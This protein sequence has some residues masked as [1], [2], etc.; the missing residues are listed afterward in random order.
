MHTF[1][2]KSCKKI[3][4]VASAGPNLTL[5]SRHQ[6]SAL[7]GGSLRTFK[8]IE[9]PEE[10]INLCHMTKRCEG[11]EYYSE[12]YP[13]I[14]KKK[15]CNL[16]RSAEGFLEEPFVTSGRSFYVCLRTEFHD[17]E[18]VGQN[19]GSLRVNN[20]QQCSEACQATPGCVG[21]TQQNSSCFLKSNIEYL[22]YLPKSKSEQVCYRPPS[23]VNM[24]VN[25]DDVLGKCL[26]VLFLMIHT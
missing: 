13:D 21:F 15:I 14:W 25:T 23:Y 7:I 8:N 12:N 26:L 5:V 20:S 10:C 16:K 9:N 24:S 3:S 1:S 4:P 17:Q 18:A 11:Y 2:G 22:Q 19:I 6:N